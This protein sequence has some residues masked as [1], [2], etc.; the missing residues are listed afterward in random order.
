MKKVM[1]LLLALCLAAAPVAAAAEETSYDPFRPAAEAALAALEGEL[2]RLQGSVYV[3]KDFGDTENHFTQKA[4]MAGIDERLVLDMDE[5][6]RDGPH[7]GRSCIRCQQVTVPGDWGGWLFLNGYLPAGETAPR[8]N[9]GAL[10]GQGLDLSGATSLSFWAR[11]A[12]GGEK[13]EFFTCGFGYDGEWGVKIAPYADSAGKRSLGTVTLTADWREYTMDLSDADMSYIVCGFGYVLSGETSGAADNVFFLDD[14]RFVGDFSQRDAH[15]LLRSYDTDNIYI[16]NAAFSYDNALAAMAFLS[17]GR[18]EAAERLLDAFVYAVG[19][20]RYAPG[21]IRNA[22]AAGDITAF[23]GWNDAARLP[24][25]YDAKDGQWYEDRYQTGSNVGNTS[26]V[27]LALLQ[28]D[29]LYGSETYLDTA[30]ALMDWVID[31]CSDGTPGFTGG[32]DGWPEGGEDTTYVFTYKSIEHN[33][34][35]YAAFRQLYART[36]E[37]RYAEAARSALQLIDSLYDED[38]QLFYTGTLDDGTTPSTGNLVLDA[39]V[40]ACL[41]LGADF[42]PYEGSLDLVANMRTPEGGYPFCAANGNGGW[43]AEG[44]AYTALMYRL[45]GEDADAASALAALQGIQLQSGLLPAA[46]VEDLSTGFELFDG[47]PWVYGTAPHIA[48]AAWFVM[49]VNGFNPYAFANVS[50]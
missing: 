11:G 43:W 22:Y 1:T 2:Q 16:Q 38:K 27:A 50:C 7:S 13:V 23:P 26:Y 30:K 12:R 3:Y 41:A 29:A 18:K 9:D 44:T 32:Y 33:I 42:V 14:I 19:H 36:G 37:A 15:Y 35:A 40:W 31:N 21:R 45:R 6:W 28:Y 10:D 4:K 49:A 20:D 39:Q 48:P 8:L 5:N 17:A 46:T 25:W 34:D 47:S 24:G